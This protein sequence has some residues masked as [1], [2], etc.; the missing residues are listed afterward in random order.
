MNFLRAGSIQHYQRL[1]RRARHY[2]KNLFCPFTTFERKKFQFYF[3]VNMQTYITYMITHYCLLQTP[4]VTSRVFTGS[5]SEEG[6]YKTI[7]ASAKLDRQSIF[8]PTVSDVY[9]NILMVILLLPHTL[10]HTL[11][12]HVSDHG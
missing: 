9:Y 5:M 7:L 1:R 11:N 6:L 8:D 3:N 12:I 10:L 4:K 2:G